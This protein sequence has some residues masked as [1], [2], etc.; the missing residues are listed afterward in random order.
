MILHN[1][2]EKNPD[3]EDCGCMSSAKGRA[4][5][6]KAGDQHEEGKGVSKRRDLRLNSRAGD[7]ADL[8]QNVSIYN[9]ILVD[10]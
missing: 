7:L 6:D 9:N 2:K 5:S 1:T 8:I 4:G 10:D 3:D